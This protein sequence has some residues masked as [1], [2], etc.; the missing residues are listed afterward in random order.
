MLQRSATAETGATA[1][2]T[3]NGTAT[4]TSF[5]EST[6]GVAIAEAFASSEVLTRRAALHCGI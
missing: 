1:I 4:A 3:G 2:S 5:A 6:E